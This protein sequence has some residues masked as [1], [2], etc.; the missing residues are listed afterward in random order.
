MNFGVGQLVTKP[1]IEHLLPEGTLAPPFVEPIDDEA[2]E[3]EQGD[4]TI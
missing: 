1:L 2:T 4:G 3:C